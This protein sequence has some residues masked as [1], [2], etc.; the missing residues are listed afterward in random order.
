LARLEAAATARG[1][2]WLNSHT[3]DEKLALG[4][5]PVRAWLASVGGA[6][7]WKR[8]GNSPPLPPEV[9]EALVAGALAAYLAGAPPGSRTGRP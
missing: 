8:A 6:E 5:E 9:L 1:L 2:A 4:G 7:A 3:E